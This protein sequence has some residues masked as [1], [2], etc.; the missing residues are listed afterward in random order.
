MWL[1]S[2]VH[3]RMRVARWVRIHTTKTSDEKL[4][5]QTSAPTTLFI[6]IYI[7]YFTHSY[8]IERVFIAR[9]QSVIITPVI[10]GHRAIIICRP[11]MR[12]YSVRFRA[13]RYVCACLWPV[14]WTLVYRYAGMAEIVWERMQ[15]YVLYEHFMLFNYGQI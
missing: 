4:N 1:C 3:R 8:L 14:M 7:E 13:R 9:L 12:Y 6:Y 10:L 5:Y 11:G 2:H 15:E